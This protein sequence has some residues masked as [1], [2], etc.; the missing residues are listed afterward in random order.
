MVTPNS[1]FNF[2]KVSI[3][4]VCCLAVH[5]IGRF[6]SEDKFRLKLCR[7]LVLNS[8]KITKHYKKLYKKNSLKSKRWLI[9]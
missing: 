6:I 9:I 3:K 5:K 1:E 8:E 7:L 4:T 2:P